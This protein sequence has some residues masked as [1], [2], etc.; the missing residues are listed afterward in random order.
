MVFTDLCI[1]Y[2]FENTLT[3][4]CA[5]NHTSIWGRKMNRRRQSLFCMSFKSGYNDI[6]FCFFILTR[7]HFCIYVQIEWEGERNIDVRDTYNDIFYINQNV[8]SPFSINLFSILNQ[9]YFVSKLFET[10]KMQDMQMELVA[11]DALRVEY[12]RLQR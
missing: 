11:V 10:F 8:L 2:Y 6:I 1:D 12:C 7:G 4:Y 5:R 3:T 9:E